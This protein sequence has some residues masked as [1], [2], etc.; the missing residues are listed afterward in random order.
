[1]AGKKRTRR[2]S[3]LQSGPH[4]NPRRKVSAT[5]EQWA[6][7]DAAAARMGKSWAV[8]TRDYWDMIAPP[9]PTTEGGEKKHT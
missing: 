4:T 8:A 6:R 7:W 9:E 1:M 3:T 2:G 5:A